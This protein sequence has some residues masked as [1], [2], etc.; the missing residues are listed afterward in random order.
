MVN[1]GI[2]SGHKIIAAGRKVYQGKIS[3]IKT[4]VLPTIVKRI[5]SFLRHAGFYRRFIQYFSK[6]ARPLCRLLEKDTKC[7]FDEAC[8]TAFEEIRAR[9]V[10]ALVI[11][12]PNWNKNFE[13]MCDD[14]DLSM[15]AILGRELKRP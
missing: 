8:R 10:I 12:T 4:L 5:I 13:I 2:V 7:D 14:S 1:E 15:G 3:V 9:L 6:I 11:E